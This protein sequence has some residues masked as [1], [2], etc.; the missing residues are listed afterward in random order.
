MPTAPDL[1]H[2]FGLQPKAAVDY[3]R[4]LGWKIT[5]DWRETADAVRAKSFA[6]SNAARLDILKDLRD[7]LQSAL[8]DGTTERDFVNKLTPILQSKGWWGTQIA[9][10]ATGDAQRIHMGNPARLKMI[11]RTNVQSAMMAGRWRQFMAN[12]DH[13]PYFQ[14]LAIMD[15]RTRPTH[16]AMN[17]RIFRYDDPIWNTHWPP[18]AYNCRCRVRALSESGVNRSGHEVESS[19]GHL[20]TVQ[21]PYGIDQRTGE[22][23]ERPGTVLRTIGPDGKPIDVGPA[24]GFGFNPGAGDNWD[25]IG[26]QP[27]LPAGAVKS[28]SVATVARFLPGQPTWRDLKLPDLRTIAASERLPAPA[29][30]PA[31]PDVASA[32]ALVAEHLGVSPGEPSR[33]VETPIDT[34]PIQYSL[35][36]HMVEKRSDARERYA[37][38]VLPTLTQ[39]FE[40][41][42]TRYDDGSLRRRY[43]GAFKGDKNL[44]SIVRVNGDGSVFWNYMQANDK[45]LNQL[46][47]GQLLWSKGK[48]GGSD[49]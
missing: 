36:S 38:Y 31:Q 39:P 5:W 28:A 40:V 15:S 30:L 32:L 17:A 11:Y 45:R 33:L 19:A 18:W 6:A 13:A 48:P 29:L 7:G 42:A 37:A 49:K 35:L 21:Q 46:R 26:N 4:S 12:V 34:V 44:L 47:V 20:H 14:Y 43:I 2:A 23:I 8:A 25:P 10:D 3:F 24:P 1:S 9:V 27:D 16:A 41:W 22:V